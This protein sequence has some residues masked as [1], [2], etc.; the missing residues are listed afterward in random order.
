[1]GFGDIMAYSIGCSLPW[2]GIGICLFLMLHKLFPGSKV[3]NYVLYNIPPIAGG[4]GSWTGFDGQSLLFPLL[5]SLL[6]YI[7]VITVLTN[8]NKR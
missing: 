4:L 8:T 6:W 5:T 1:M 3:W 7:A 2:G